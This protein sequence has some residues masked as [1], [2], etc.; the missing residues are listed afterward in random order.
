MLLGKKAKTLAFSIISAAIIIAYHVW[1]NLYLV[2]GGFPWFWY[3]ILP[4]RWWPV[5]IA[6]KDR[7]KSG[8]FFLVSLAIFFAYYIVLNLILSPTYIWAPYLTYPALWLVMGLYIYKKKKPLLFSITS[9]VIKAS[10]IKI[11]N[12][13]RFN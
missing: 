1:L 3:M 11:I 2:P 13:C 8:R 5:S 12:I 4:V 7:A 10:F 6:L 9:T